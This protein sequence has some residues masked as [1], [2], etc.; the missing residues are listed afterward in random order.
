MTAAG[1]LEP[2]YATGRAAWASYLVNGDA[3]GIDD[4]ERAEADRFAAY[5]GGPIVSADGEPFHAVPHYPHGGLPGPCLTYA[6][7]VRDDGD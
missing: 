4:G 5:M 3:S 1:K 6:A 2:V 7:L